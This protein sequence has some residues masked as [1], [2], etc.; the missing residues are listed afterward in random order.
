MNTPNGSL[1]G[2][3]GFTMFGCAGW[4]GWLDCVLRKA[5]GSLGCWFT[6]GFGAGW[7]GCIFNNPNGS[8]DG[9]CGFTMAGCVGWACTFRNANG[10]LL[11]L[12]LFCWFCGG[13]TDG[14]FACG[15][16]G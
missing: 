11:A 13:K 8:L 5:K 12:L 10:S 4:A 9:G 6:K 7:E 3:S 14:W 2:G 1:D 15:L 16:A